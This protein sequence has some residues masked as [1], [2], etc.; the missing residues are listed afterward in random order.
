MSPTI[1]DG[2]RI[3]TDKVLRE[4]TPPERGDVVVFR[5]PDKVDQKWVRRVIALPG[6]RVSVLGGEVFVNGKKLDRDRVPDSHLGALGGQIRGQVF[7]ENNSG[8]S[9]LVQI[10]GGDKHAADFPEKTVP[11]GQYFLLGDNRDRSFDSRLAGFVPRGEIIGKAT[12]IY[13]PVASWSRFGTL[14]L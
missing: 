3:L 6:D 2:D 8:S 4:S 10:G 12:Y 7:K 1:L 13:L 5:V 14:K 11:E 9:Y